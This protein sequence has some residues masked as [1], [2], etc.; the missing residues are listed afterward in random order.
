[1]KQTEIKYLEHFSNIE[2]SIKV[3][4]EKLLKQKQGFQN[5]KDN[6]GYVGDLSYISEELKNILEFF[7]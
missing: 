2:E 4:Q 3:L 7:V 1:M 5:N 6:W